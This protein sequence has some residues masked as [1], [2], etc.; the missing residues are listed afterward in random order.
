MGKILIE[1]TLTQCRSVSFSLARHT[2]IGEYVEYR[3]V[4]YIKCA[5]DAM[6]MGALL[7]LV[8]AA[9]CCVVFIYKPSIRVVCQNDTHY[10]LFYRWYTA[11]A[12]AC[13][14]ACRR[15]RRRRHRHRHRRQSS[16]TSSSRWIHNMTSTNS[17][18]SRVFRINTF[19]AFIFKIVRAATS[20][21][22]ASNAICFPY[23]WR[24]YLPTFSE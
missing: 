15:R 16:T 9:S 14:P 5:L 7:C 6:W 10:R 3:K 19:V 24:L 21:H 18:S 22:M 8:T 13:L 23:I 20:I 12:A 11:A 17:I 4:E 2:S 1:N